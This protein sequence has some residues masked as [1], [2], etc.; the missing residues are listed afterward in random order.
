MVTRVGPDPDLGGV[1]GLRLPLVT[2]GESVELCE[3]DWDGNLVWSFKDWPKPAGATTVA[4]QHHDYEREGNPVGYYAPGQD[5]V[6]NGKTLILTA[7][8]MKAPEVCQDVALLEDV[9]YEVGSEGEILWQWFSLDHFAELGFD[10]SALEF[11]ADP[12]AG[13]DPAAVWEHF[14]YLHANAI[15]VLGKNKWYSERGD[16]RFDPSNIMISYRSS[17]IVAIISRATGRIV[18]KIGP[19][20]KEGAAEYGLGQI[21]GQHAA[22]LIPEGL[23]GA[24]NVLLF[25]NG[26]QSGYGGEEGY[27]RYQRDYSRVL[28]FDPVTLRK[29][30]DYAADG[31]YSAFVSNAQRLPNGN[32]LICQGMG[33]RIFEVTPD[34]EVVW[35]LTRRELVTRKPGACDGYTLFVGMDGEEYKT[36]LVDM[37]GNT[38]H[39]WDMVGMPVK[40]LS[41]GSVLGNTRPDIALTGPAGSEASEGEAPTGLVAMVASGGMYRAYRIPPEWVPGNVTGYESWSEYA[42]ARERG[43]TDSPRASSQDRD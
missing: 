10:G 9:V 17:N 35:E 7:A 11:I 20:F 26:G 13:D 37:D 41:N 5:Y 21:V 25:D 8:V 32:T 15:S 24:G 31:F 38:V 14:D 30:W 39:S 40:M 12:R 27:P 28:E 33:G 29:V 36:L 3:M 2:W 19:D 23:P 43:G 42:V 22:H 34:K 18:W 4:Y 16:E 1:A 6:T